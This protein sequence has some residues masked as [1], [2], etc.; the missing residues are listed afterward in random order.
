MADSSQPLILFYCRS[1]SV[2]HFPNNF[3]NLRQK[4]EVGRSPPPSSRRPKQTQGSD[5]TLMSQ[6][7]NFTNGGFLTSRSHSQ[8]RPVMQQIASPAEIHEIR[9][10]NLTNLRSH[11]SNQVPKISQ[12]KASVFM[13]SIFGCFL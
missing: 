8:N 9:A 13:F 3:T 1:A 5:E 11:H 12:V 2:G 7:R 4:T 10:A 6:L